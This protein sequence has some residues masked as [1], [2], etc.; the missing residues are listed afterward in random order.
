M[1]AHGRHVCNI[2]KLETQPKWCSTGEWVSKLAQPNQ[3]VLLSK[4]KERAIV[5]T[6]TEN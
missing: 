6:M 3:G 2:P 1:N 4:K 5:H